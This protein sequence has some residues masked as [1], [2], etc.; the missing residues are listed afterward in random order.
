MGRYF[1]RLSYD[2]TH[3]HGW[4]MQQNAHSV[5]AELNDKLSKLLGE[6]LNVV[7]CGRTDA[8]VHA[9][10]FYAH[11][12]A[13][14]LPLSPKDLARKLNGF[15][16]EDIA[17]DRIFAVDG[18]M[19]ARFSALSR[20][21][22]YFITR[23][24]S[25]FQR[26]FSYVLT[27]P[28]DVEAMQEATAILPEYD[29]FTSFS[30]LHTQTATNICKI[31]EA[32][33]EL[34]EDDLVFTITADRFLRNMVRA[35]VGTLLEIGKGKLK[36]ADMRNIIEAKDRSRAGFSVPAQ[37]LFLEKVVYPEEF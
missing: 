28:L 14:K 26:Y 1:I 5:Q 35:I 30:K 24:K 8:G 2:G 9:S 3:Y 6:K 27:T 16:P 20:T 34:H 36:P 11:F 23:K 17:I 32:R 13:E 22:K 31:T 33:W 4:Q 21:Y 37:G 7:G 10:E 25:P 18:E 15:L 29:D 12:E 19:H